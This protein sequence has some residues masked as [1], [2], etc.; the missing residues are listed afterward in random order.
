[1]NLLGESKNLNMSYSTKNSGMSVKFEFKSPS[2]VL[3]FQILNSILTPDQLAELSPPQINSNVVILS[4]RGPLWLYSYLVHEYHFK[5]I[6]ATFEPRLNKGIV[7]ISVSDNDIG[8]GIDIESGKLEDVKLGA[9]GKLK[10]ELLV[11]EKSNI[12]IIKVSIEGDRFI[13]PSEM[14]N[15]NYPDVDM[16]KP[17]V[18]FGFMPVWLASRLTAYYV[19]RCPY[20]AVYDPRIGGAI[21]TATHS[22]KKVGEVIEIDIK[23]FRIKRWN[24][25]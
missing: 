24:I 18:I 7:V 14:K 22:K 25:K 19:H 11:S 12:Q 15:I 5:R 20:F 2:P 21:V 4:G 23:D 10:L 9:N 6:V 13:E 17:I 8:K 3:E 1:M 16:T